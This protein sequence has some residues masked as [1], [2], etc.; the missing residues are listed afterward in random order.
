MRADIRHSQADLVELRLV[1]RAV[2]L[3]VS[4]TDRK[5]IPDHALAWNHTP[6]VVVGYGFGNEMGV[7]CCWYVSVSEN[8]PVAP[9]CGLIGRKF[10]RYRPQCPVRRLR[11]RS[12]R[13]RSHSRR[14]VQS[15]RSTEMPHPV[16]GQSRCALPWPAHR[17]PARECSEDTADSPS[18]A[19]PD[20]RSPHP[21]SG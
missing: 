20:P 1:R 7:T 15:G 8:G 14:A 2:L 9:S 12:A 21:S 3:D 13:Y 16:S 11:S 19:L 5:R 10:A 18:R 4:M 17:R 6:V